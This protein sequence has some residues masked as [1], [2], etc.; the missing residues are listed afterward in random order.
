MKAQDTQYI[1]QRDYAIV[2]ED[3]NFWDLGSQPQ[4]WANEREILTT[5]ADILQ[6]LSDW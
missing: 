4:R 2:C 6:A 1:A 3:V 5:A